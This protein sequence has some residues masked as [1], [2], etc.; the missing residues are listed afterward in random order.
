MSIN[1][2]DLER[3]SLTFEV[4]TAQNEQGE[5]IITGRPVV[6]GQKVNI[7]G[8][9]YEVI[10]R[11]ALDETDLRDIPFI[12]NHDL[13]RLPY[14]RSRN[15]NANSTMHF[16]RSSDGLDLDWIKLD[17]ERNVESKA[18]FSA[19]D[20]RD[21]DSMSFSF[22]VREEWW[23]DLDTN[24]PTR[25]ITKIKR[26]YEVSAVTWAAYSDTTIDV[27]RSSLEL[28]SAKATLENARKRAKLLPEGNEQR[29]L[30]LIK[31]KTLIK[32]NHRKENE[33]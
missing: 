24:M 19:V 23:E 2:K 13:V 15:N 14:A 6:Y 9:F 21:I 16:T 7:S 25:H 30:E 26:I 20:R 28:E 5:N 31:L 11:G 33:L 10:E 22:S 32:H 27:A 3:R 12:L 4:R 29:Q 8:L 17:T 18:L 1:K